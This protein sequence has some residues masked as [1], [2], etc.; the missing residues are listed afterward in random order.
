MLLRKE[1]MDCRNQA[2]NNFT[3]RGERHF[4]SPSLGRVQNGCHSGTGETRAGTKLGGFARLTL[5][6][7]GAATSLL[8]SVAGA[9]QS[10][11]YEL[12]LR[13]GRVLSVASIQGDPARELEVM[14]AGQLQKLPAGDLLAVHGC[15]AQTI[16]LAC[17]TLLGDEVVTGALVGGDATGDHFV[18]MSP[19]LGRIE[20]PVDRLH[21]LS[22]P[23][24]R[25][26]GDLPLP[27]GVSEAIFRRAAV[28]YDIVA[29][30]LHEFGDRGV[31]FQP[32]GESE[33]RWF[34]VQ[35]MAGLRLAEAEPRKLAP[36]A[37]L[38]TR[39]GDSL[40]I[41]VRRFTSKAIE[42]E[43]ENG[44]RVALAYADLA[45]LSF[46]GTA[47]FLSDLTPIE[48]REAGFDGPT[49]YSWRRD[50]SVLGTPL[51]AGQRTYGKGLGMHSRSRLC[52][53]VPEGH[54]AFW[55]RVALDDSAAGLPIAALV[56][57]RV[58]VNDKVCF[59]YKGLAVGKPPRDTGLLRVAPGDRLAL[60]VDFGAGRDLGDRVDWL[61]PVLLP[62]PDR[63]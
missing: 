22:A 55:S 1:L 48:V 56:D 12:S 45:S 41:T 36:T 35:E 18:M 49:L 52:F 15:A 34:R 7:A 47:T 53:E 61:L 42:C 39:T 2:E 33:P 62:A 10:P 3:E 4:G 27:S 46:T 43:L 16:D 50:Q 25:G 14:V 13:D 44:A 24:A 26:V 57:V 63:Q 32:D 11:T 38:R 31:R 21:A 9:A 6:A 8:L 40:G 23:G 5:R 30:S 29:G 19:S 54:V 60:E 37:F 58:L 20:L 51:I 28:G 17:A 59:E